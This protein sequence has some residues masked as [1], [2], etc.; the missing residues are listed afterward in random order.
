MLF[1]LGLPSIN[2]CFCHLLDVYIIHNALVHINLYVVLIWAVIYEL[3]LPSTCN[4]YI[5]HIVSAHMILYVVPIAVA[6]IELLFLPSTCNVYI[7]H[8]ALIARLSGMG[9]KELLV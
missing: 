2:C 8:N 6:I 9:A 4:I 1:Q 7:I 3:F 5:I